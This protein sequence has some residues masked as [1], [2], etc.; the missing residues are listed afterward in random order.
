M[1]H[2]YVLLCLIVWGGMLPFFTAL[3]E[4]ARPETSESVSAS[5]P[6]T[7]AEKTVPSFQL[8]DQYGNAHSI[9]FPRK[10]TCVLLLADQKGSRQL[11]PWIRP[12]YERYQD[13][14]DIL[15]VAELSAVPPKLRG[16]GRLLFRKALTYPVMLDWEGKVCKAYDHAPG[17]ANVLVLDAQGHVLLRVNA[18]VDKSLLD[19]VYSEIDATLTGNGS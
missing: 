19:Q 9:Q 15:G 2:I 11:E 14:I 8:E 18:E 10:K 5:S 3:P 13:R 12:L 16:L 17:A 1:P 6:A 7:P 4:T